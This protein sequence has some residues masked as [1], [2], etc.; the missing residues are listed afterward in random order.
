MRGKYK[1]MKVDIKTR[2]GKIEVDIPDDIFRAMGENARD[3][4]NYCGWVV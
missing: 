1:C 2:N 3:I 4:V